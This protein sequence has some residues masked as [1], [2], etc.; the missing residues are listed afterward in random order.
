MLGCA[1]FDLPGGQVTVWY[2]R[3][4]DVLGIA[5]LAGGPANENAQALAASSLFRI[6]SRALTGAARCPGRV[7]QVKL[8]RVRPM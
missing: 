4:G 7:G 3:D 5:V 6:N 8:G 1:R 2:A